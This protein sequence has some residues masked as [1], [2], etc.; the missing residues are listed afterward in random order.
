MIRPIYGN[1]SRLKRVIYA[2]RELIGMMLNQETG[3]LLYAPIIQTNIDHALNEN[4]LM[5]CRRGRLS[6]L[7]FAPQVLEIVLITFF[8]SF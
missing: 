1:F 7:F 3:P 2:I 4:R 5:W 6:E 8:Q